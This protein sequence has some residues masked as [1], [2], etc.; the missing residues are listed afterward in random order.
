M[1]NVTSDLWSNPNYFSIQENFPNIFHMQRK[2]GLRPQ[3]VNF[4]VI[5]WNFDRTE[6]K[7]VLTLVSPWLKTFVKGPG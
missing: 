4:Q 7:T 1:S 3:I 5:S 2:K 6:L